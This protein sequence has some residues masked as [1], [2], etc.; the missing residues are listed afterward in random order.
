[1]SVWK[2]D[3]ENSN[4]LNPIGISRIKEVEHQLGVLLPTLYVEMILE[5]N[6]GEIIYNACPSPVPTVWGE[7]YVKVD[8]I[9]GIEEDGGILVSDQYINE[10]GMPKNLILLNGD[11]HTWIALDYRKNKEF[12]SVIFID[13]ER[14]QI[15]ELALNYESFIKKL[16][17]VEESDFDVNVEIVDMPTY[18]ENEIIKEIKTTDLIKLIDIIGMMSYTYNQKFTFEQYKKLLCHSQ[19]EVR[20]AI[21]YQLYNLLML[22]E[23]TEMKNLRELVRCLSKDKDSEVTSYYDFINEEL[24]NRFA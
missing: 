5:Q 7:K 20:I 10:W 14:E 16:M 18:S 8:S 22:N 15:I 1:M 19:S 12:P 2:R 6:G 17:T 21:A 13:N 23:V 4:V 3:E 24:K 9:M 11:G